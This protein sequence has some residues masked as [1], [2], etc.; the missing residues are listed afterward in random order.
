MVLKVQVQVVVLTMLVVVVKGFPKAITKVAP[1]VIAMIALTRVVFH[2][3]VS[4]V[5]SHLV[6]QV[7][8]QEVT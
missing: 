5:V 8:F 4:Q 6:S 2:M 3:E 7:V 1:S